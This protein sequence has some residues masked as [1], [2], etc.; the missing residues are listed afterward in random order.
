L[1]TLVL[2]TTAILIP[3][4]PVCALDDKEFCVAAKQ[5][6]TAVDKDIGIWIDRVTRNAGVTVSCD[7]KVV[8]FKRFLYV[9][10]A[11]LN[12]AWQERKAAEWNTTHCSSPLWQEAIRSGWKISVSFWVADGS[13]VSLHARCQ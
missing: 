2:R 7:K 9:P 10:A 4:T 6:A 11:S 8:E 1:L 5:I 3:L 12:E 13:H